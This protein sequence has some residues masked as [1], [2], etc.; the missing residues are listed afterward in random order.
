MP[1]RCLAVSNRCEV[2]YTKLTFPK[3]ARTG[4]L[5]TC[6]CHHT[7]VQLCL[8]HGQ[9]MWLTRNNFSFPTH[10]TLIA[11]IEEV[12]FQLLTDGGIIYIYIELYMSQQY[13]PRYPSDTLNTQ[14]WGLTHYL[15]LAESWC[16]RVRNPLAQKHRPKHN[17]GVFSVNCLYR[18]HYKLKKN[19]WG[20]WKNTKLH[21]ELYAIV[22]QYG[23]LR[24]AQLERSIKGERDGHSM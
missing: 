24:R 5:H 11:S 22:S 3:T 10:K 8:S 1:R 6:K 9:D 17:L 23:T 21:N 15:Y 18:M 2:R 4:Q 12:A 19:K 7:A 20:E 16:P 13:L 14:L